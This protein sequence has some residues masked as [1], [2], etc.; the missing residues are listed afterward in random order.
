MGEEEVPTGVAAVCVQACYLVSC[1]PTQES[2][3]R[4]CKYGLSLTCS[5]QAGR[6]AGR[7][8]AAT[9]AGGCGELIG[10][11]LVAAVQG[12]VH[13][14][15]MCSRGD[16]ARAELAVEAVALHASSRGSAGA[17]DGPHQGQQWSPFQGELSADH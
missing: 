4:E 1:S 11:S 7:Y 10:C 3:W 17:I 5:R 9:A 2:L 13:T 14:G 15:F 6:Q 16:V 8:T 12:R